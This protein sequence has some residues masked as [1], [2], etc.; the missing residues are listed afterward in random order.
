MVFRVGTVEGQVTRVVPAMEL[1][2]LVD[3]VR[4]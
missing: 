4:N 1:H 3:I 2:P